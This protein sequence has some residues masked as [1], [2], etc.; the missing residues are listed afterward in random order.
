[1]G[2]VQDDR[3]DRGGPFRGE[4]IG[5]RTFFGQGPHFLDSN[6]LTDH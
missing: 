1:M 5:P 6:R 2:T 4:G 3:F